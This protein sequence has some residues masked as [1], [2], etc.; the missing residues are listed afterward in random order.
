MYFSFNDLL[1]SNSNEL[2]ATWNVQVVKGKITTSCL[3]HALRA[4]IVGV[5]LMTIG[6]GMATIGNLQIFFYPKQSYA[7]FYNLD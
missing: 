7:I 5:V 2:G 1:I 3:W 4:L 6:A